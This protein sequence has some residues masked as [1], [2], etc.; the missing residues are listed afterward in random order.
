[1]VLCPATDAQ[2]TYVSTHWVQSCLENQVVSS[3]SFCPKEVTAQ[4]REAGPCTVSQFP[5]QAVQMISGDNPFGFT[6][7]PQDHRNAPAQTVQGK[8]GSIVGCGYDRSG[9][10]ARE[11]IFRNK[12]ARL[13]KDDQNLLLPSVIH[14]RDPVSNE[15]PAGSNKVKDTG[16]V[17]H[18]VPDVAASIE[19]WLEQISK[20]NDHKSPERNGGDKAAEMQVK[21]YLVAGFS[22]TQTDSQVGGFSIVK[23]VLHCLRG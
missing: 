20:I 1:M 22:E 15:N 3:D 12:K 7:D 14:L 5:T 6:R 13:L 18:V 2:I 17:A 10:E 16:E 21:A 9:N 4:D 19:D 23:L 11:S 8:N